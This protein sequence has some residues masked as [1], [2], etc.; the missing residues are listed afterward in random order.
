MKH[1]IQIM[2]SDQQASYLKNV[3]DKTGETVASLVRRAVAML[4]R[5]EGIPSPRPITAVPAP[6]PRRVITVP[7]PLPTEQSAGER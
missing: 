2:L 3:S 4:M 7:S 1:R 6:A 5:F